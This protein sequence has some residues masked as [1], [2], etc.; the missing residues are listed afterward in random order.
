MK[1]GW[2]KELPG[3]LLNGIVNGGIAALSAFTGSTLLGTPAAEGR[4]VSGATAGFMFLLTF[5]LEIRKFLD[6]SKK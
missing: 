6:L 4:A 5:L 1:K 2:Y 3:A